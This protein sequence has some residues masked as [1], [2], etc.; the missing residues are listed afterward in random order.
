MKTVSIDFSAAMAVGDKVIGFDSI[1]KCFFEL[2]LI[3]NEIV[4]LENFYVGNENAGE[5]FGCPYLYENRLY[6]PP[7]NSKGIIAISD[8]MTRYEV[9]SYSRL[10][11]RFSN[12]YIRDNKA[13]LLPGCG[14]GIVLF[15]FRTGKEKKIDGWF[16]KYE[17][18]A[19]KGQTPSMYGKSRYGAGL[20]LEDELL[21]PL[22]HTS[23]LLKVRLTA[24]G[25]EYNAK[26]NTGYNEEYNT[27]LIEIADGDSSG[28]LAV[29]GDKKHK[30]VLTRTTK[31][32]LEI[33]DNRV[34]DRH[35]LRLNDTYAGRSLLYD[36]KIFVLG[37]DKAVL[38]CFDIKSGE[39]REIDLST[40]LNTSESAEFGVFIRIENGFFI[41][42]NNSGK[43]IIG[44]R[45]VG[46]YSVREMRPLVNEDSAAGLICK[47]VQEDK[48][49]E[50]NELFTLERF[51]KT[52]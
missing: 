43:I 2:S 14:K 9:S 26:Y 37:K 3:N 15:D 51:I 25:M 19:F 34:I 17:K 27:E 23:M 33:E 44:E 49:I 30:F 13:F 5:S 35:K 48:V 7:C 29:Y 22:L 11:H 21:L 41:T 18:K 28:L 16:E 24:Y 31:E 45:G 38:S 39:V 1:S 20:V 10:P 46:N 36:E 32:L 50:E 52:I 8:E 47:R 42:E 6:F 40:V 12:I 4:F